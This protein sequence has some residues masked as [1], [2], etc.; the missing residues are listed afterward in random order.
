MSLRARD[1]SVVAGGCTLLDSINVDFAAGELTM[2]VGP[3]G[4]GKTTLLRCLDGEM[5]PTRGAV[6][7]ADQPIRAWRRDELARRRAVLPQQSSL[8][9]PFSALDVVL[10]GRMPHRTSPA[11]DRAIAE[12]ALA[13]CDAAHLQ[14]RAY[15]QLSGG[16]QQRVQIARVLAQAAD[17]GD[18]V[19]ESNS[20]SHSDGRSDNQSNGERKSKPNSKRNVARDNE[21][22]AAKFLLLDEPVAALDLRHQHALLT[23][24]RQLTQSGRCGVICTLH[25]LNLAA[26]FADR[27]IVLHE[28]KV[29]DDGAPRAVFNEAT[30]RRVFGVSVSVREHP[31]DCE[32]VLLVP[33]IGA[34]RS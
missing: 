28:G 32:V 8:D 31:D 23:V 1:V 21:H 13:M 19:S 15:T 22:T 27:A 14:P 33:R 34:A 20:D 5:T 25:N 11:Q 7:F 6:D 4:A 30:I 24:L 16:E 2:I 18:G 29:V 10:M 26:Q 12:H 9:F 17:E 3:N